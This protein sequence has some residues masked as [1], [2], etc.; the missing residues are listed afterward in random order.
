MAQV[1]DRRWRKNRE[2][3]KREA[4]GYDGPSPW[5]A[6]WRDPDGI[7][8]SKGFARKVDAEQYLVS[9]E[10]RKLQGDYVDPN[11]GKVTV[12]EWC[13]TWRRLQVH[14][15]STATQVE[16]YFRLHLYPKLGDRQLRSLRPSDVQGWVTERSG[17]LAAGSVELMFRHFSAAMKAAEH[18]R[19]IGRTPCQRIKLPKKATVE[20]V[21]PTLEQVEALADAIS[22][23][24]RAAVVLAAGAGLRLGEVFGV[25]VDRLDLMRRTVTVDQQL[26]TPGRGPAE[27][28]PPKTAS[29]VRTVPIADV[30]VHELST[31]LAQFP[32]VDGF[33]FTTELDRPVRRSTFQDAW[34]RALKEAGVGHVRF[35]DLRHHYASALISAGCS[36]KAVQKALGHAS[37][38]ETLETYAHLWPDDEDRTRDAI[39]ALWTPSDVREMCAVDPAGE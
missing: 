3:G 24:Y 7:Q 31:H 5:L 4:T 13:E 9:I 15:P 34:A 16:S 1:T 21:P 39:Q 26:L 10:H 32:V 30:V 6:R 36:V 18:D 25:Q 23:R 35:H 22:D 2:T 14:R 12:R 20:V 8:R 17:P 28:G 33:V 29:S 38:T 27:L 37:A 19:V 11:A